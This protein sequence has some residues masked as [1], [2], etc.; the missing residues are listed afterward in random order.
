MC[1][2][3]G[4]DMN[5]RRAPAAGL[6]R[7]ALLVLACAVALA[8]PGCGSGEPRP[9]ELYP[10]DMCAHCRMAVSDH[11]FACEIVTGAGDALKFDDIGCLDAFLKAPPP[12]AAGG[13]VF[14]K[15]YETRRG[16]PAAG[17]SIITTGIMTPMGSGKV[18]LASRGAA[19]RVAAEYPPDK[20]GAGRAPVQ[21]H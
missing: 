7:A 17:A 15:D 10:E 4:W 1:T 9:V 20:S 2:S 12:S 14:Y 13:A 16:V 21:A 19:A 18:V 3:M 6:Q 11:R 8:G 5:D